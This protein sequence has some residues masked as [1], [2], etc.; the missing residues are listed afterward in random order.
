MFV[1]TV[2][3]GATLLLGPTPALAPKTDVLYMKNGDRITCEVKT[4]DA[5][6]VYVSL[7]YVDGT[8]AVNWSVIARLESTHLFLVE[9][10]DGSVHTGRI[11]V[12]S[13][14]ETDS[15]L[16][17]V[18]QPGGPSI[19]LEVSRIA[20]LSRTSDSF[21]GRLNGNLTSGVSFAK[22]NNTTTYNIASNVN[23]PRPRWSVAMTFNSN[24]SSSSGSSTSTRNQFTLVGAHLMRW[25]NWYYT[26]FGSALQSAEQQISLQA[27]LGAGIGRYL[28]KTSNVRASVVGG[29]VYQETNYEAS[30]TTATSED[31][32][33]L[34]LL[35]TLNYVKFKRTTLT[36]TIDAIP[37]L[38]DPGRFFFGSNA[39][40]F[41][42]LFGTVNWN[43]SFYGNWDTQPPSGTSGNDYGI[44]SGLSWTFGNQ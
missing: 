12:R 23:Y 41:L 32:V 28:K 40:Y 4:M 11:S 14:A 37:S 21:F 26:G 39:S 24:L 19:T 2:L 8:I 31:L 1:G 20:G 9:L 33:G 42:K 34:M 22:G 29:V 30:V 44:N 27:N 35:G 6:A 16:M 15:V 13:I 7:D 36:L 43:L 38:T 5:G 3:L 17:E 25:N 18:T 10:D